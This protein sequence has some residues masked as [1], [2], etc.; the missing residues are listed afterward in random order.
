MSHIVV[1]VCEVKRTFLLKT[2][3]NKFNQ[4]PFSNFGDET[5]RLTDAIYLNC[6]NF[7]NSVQSL[8]NINTVS[9]VSFVLLII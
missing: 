2:F 9:C 8:Y 4:N 7:M 3:S 1:A 6:I 5:E